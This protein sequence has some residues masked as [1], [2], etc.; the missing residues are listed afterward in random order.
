MPTATPARMWTMALA[1]ALTCAAPAADATLARVV[2]DSFTATGTPV[3]PF[4]FLFAPTDNRL[5]SWS[6][7]AETDGGATSDTDSNTVFTWSPQTATAQTATATATVASSIQTDPLTALE[8]PNFSLEADATPPGP[9]GL[10]QNAFGNMLES[11]LFC[12]GDGNNFDGTSAG[13]NA[14]GSIVF[15]V[16]Y[17]LII[18]PVPGGL[19]SSAYAELDVFGTGVPNGL[20]ADFASTV[21]GD[22][23]RFMQQFTWTADLAPGDLASVGLGGTVVAQAVPEP[24]ALPLVALG[25][26]AFAGTRLRRAA[27]CSA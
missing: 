12:F 13:C 19:G 2:I 27:A 9:N 4:A 23:S 17:D 7:Q 21:A 20:Y 1:M 15:T 8:T 22:S 26:V 18:D 14:A 5:Q 11:G 25:L 10:F 6:L 24:D 3:D 16:F